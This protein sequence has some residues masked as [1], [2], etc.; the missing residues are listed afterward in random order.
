MQ[1]PGGQAHSHCSHQAT[2]KAPLAK[3]NPA[4]AIT[5]SQNSER[6]LLYLSTGYVV[7]AKVTGKSTSK[8]KN[9]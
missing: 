1:Q 4:A 2:L 7:T 9:F 3:N 6:H 5:S 8:N